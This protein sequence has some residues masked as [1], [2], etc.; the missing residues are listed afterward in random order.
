MIIISGAGIDVPA[1]DVNTSG[2]EM[3]WIVDT[4]I[5]TLGKIYGVAKLNRRTLVPLPCILF[6]VRHFGVGN[7]SRRCFDFVLQKRGQ[8]ARF[9]NWVLASH[10]MKN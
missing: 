8:S 2:R 7:G 6:V 5:K 4:Y 1:P 9:I 3:S 10:F